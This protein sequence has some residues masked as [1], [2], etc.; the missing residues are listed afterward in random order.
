MSAKSKSNRG[1]APKEPILRILCGKSAGICEF[2]GCNE[3]LFYDN[4]TTAKFNAAYVAHIIASDPGGPRGHKELS[5]KL[6]DK[7]ENLMLM[8][9]KHHT[10]IDDPSTGGKN[11]PAELL[12]DMKREHEENIEQVCNYLNKQ[13]TEVVNF[14]SS[15]KGN[16]VNIIYDDTV[17]AVLPQKQPTSQYGTII[18]INS[19]F[20]ITEKNHWSDLENKL[21][22]EFN[23]KVKPAFDR[24]NDMH[25]SIFPLAP[26][27]LIIKLGE[28]FGDKTNVDIYQKTRTPDTW[29]WQSGEQTNQFSI[30]KSIVNNGKDV[31]LLLSLTDIIEECRVTNIIAP[32]A[33]YKI[34]AEH[35]GVDCIRSEKDLSAFWH[36]YQNACNEILNTFGGDSRIH[37]FSAMPV[38]AAFEVGSR[39]MP[40]LYPIT[41]IYDDNSGFIPTIT[42]GG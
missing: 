5:Q 38:S 34:I 36:T 30:S 39:R 17:K 33:I 28:L 4:V 31:A 41:I 22:F 32:N 16:Q 9:D 21:I 20:P 23:S 14:S 12:Q 25:F 6:S 10:L 29:A 27:P 37:L 19:V 35:N 18:K 1:P 13:R 15:I 24:F 26:M 42:I 8:C 3:R 40:G 11:F 7:L 2:R